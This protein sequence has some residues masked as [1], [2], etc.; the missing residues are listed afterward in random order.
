VKNATLSAL[1]DEVLACRARAGAVDCF[2]ELVHRYQV[3][4]LRFLQ[5]KS[6]ARHEAEDLLQEAFLR[7]FQSLAKYREDWPFRTWLFTLSY[8]LSVSA[9]RK[10]RPVGLETDGNAVAAD[11]NPADHAERGDSR[12][13]LWEI[14]RR[15]L[16][17]EQYA[18]VWLHYAEL[19]PA[20]EVS[21][22]LGR[23]WVWVKTTLHRSRRKLAI[24]LEAFDPT[25]PLPSRAVRGEV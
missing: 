4:L 22:V 9:A 7:A 18:A 17:E 12:R 1:N 10:R 15:T 25:A 16:N 24:S 13:H 23:S 19:M 2:E 5:R 21:Q 20:R 6:P 14:A 11:A 8:R 3:P